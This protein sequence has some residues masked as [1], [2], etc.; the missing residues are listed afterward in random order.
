M[1]GT[2]ASSGEAMCLDIRGLT[3]NLGQRRAPSDVDLRL[4]I[5]D[6]APS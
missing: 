5:S 6:R 4:R 2:A 3:L 1:D